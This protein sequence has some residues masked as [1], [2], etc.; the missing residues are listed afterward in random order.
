MQKQTNGGYTSESKQ[1]GFNMEKLYPVL[2][3]AKTH[4]GRL[5]SNE[6]YAMLLAYCPVCNRRLSVK[7]VHPKYG[8]WNYEDKKAKSKNGLVGKPMYCEQC[9]SLIHPLS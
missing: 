5:I 2:K 1:K 6:R 7:K 3:N 4:L 9:G 8:I